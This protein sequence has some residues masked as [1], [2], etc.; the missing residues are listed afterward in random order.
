MTSN[1][2]GP[3]FDGAGFDGSPRQTTVHVKQYIV[4]HVTHIICTPQLITEHK[5]LLFDQITVASDTEVMQV[6]N[7]NVKRANCSEYLR[8]NIQAVGKQL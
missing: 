1:S 7:N 6:I 3:D 8:C 2:D 4:H 5:L